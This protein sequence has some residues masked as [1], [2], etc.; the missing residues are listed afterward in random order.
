M[1]ADPSKTLVLL[2][3][4]ASLLVQVISGIWLLGFP[5]ICPDKLLDDSAKTVTIA[6]CVLSW[7]SYPWALSFCH[8]LI[9][10]GKL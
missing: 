2:V 9:A 7:N 10:L 3:Y 4:T 5:D 8:Q 1:S 6:L